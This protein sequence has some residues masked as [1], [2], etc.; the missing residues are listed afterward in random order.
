MR[1]VGFFLGFV[2]AQTYHLQVQPEATALQAQLL[3]ATQNPSAF[4]RM[5]PLWQGL[6]RVEKIFPTE[7]EGWFLVS[8]M[9]RDSLALLDS[10]QKLPGIQVLKLL[11]A[12]AFVQSLLRYLDG[13]IS[14]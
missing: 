14:L 13:I 10:L 2:W 12:V 7:L 9:G 6:R 4:A 1:R 5:A 11:Q 8:F 3:G